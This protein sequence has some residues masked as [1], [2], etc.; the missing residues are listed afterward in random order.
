[1]FLEQTIRRNKAL[2]EAA[3]ELHREG[4]IYPDSYIIDV[5][6]FL[7]N[8]EKI[9]EAGN[10]HGICLYF[11][12]KQVGRNPYLA[13]KL[14]QIGYQG[15]VAVDYKEALIMMEHQIP[16]GNV[17]HLVQIPDAM[18]SRIVQYGPQFITVYSLDK[19][20]K[21]NEA[22]EKIGKVQPLLLRIHGKSD[23][24]YPAQTAGFLLNE[25]EEIVSRIQR[26]FHHVS[27]GG[28]TSFPCFLYDEEKEDICS[29]SNL[30]TILEAAGTLK[31]LGYQ[32]LMINAPSATCVQTI[33]KM[34]HLGCNCGEPGHGLSG[35]TPMHA[36]SQ[37]EEIPSVV[38]VSEVSHNF[39]GNSFCYGGG[40]YRRSHM[41]K[42]L[43]GKSYQNAKLC[44]VKTPEEDCIDY[45]FEMPLECR[46]GD[47]VI[48]SFRYQIFVTRSDV[49]L[50]EG[51][52]SG[53]PKIAGIYD[54]LGRKKAEG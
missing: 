29:T 10:K 25:L 36:V 13:E 26:Q 14:I 38:Y 15:A 35:T 54:S 37:M 47:T 33:S 2:I 27:I 28:V 48:M 5:D 1:M 17:G 31:R 42:A 11:M 41:E 32:D 34:A 18:I 12:L 44:S 53:R 30:N 6:S 16:I 43:V 22:A 51:V 45:H 50:V 7:S 19:I 23:Y 4:L 49:V 21:I 9:L 52:Q 8:A 40:Y 39:Q 24:I 3:F 46:I 20:R